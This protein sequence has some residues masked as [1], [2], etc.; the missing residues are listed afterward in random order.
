MNAER[1]DETPEEAALDREIQALL[2][3][4]PSP[5]FQASLR[6]RI[7]DA[8]ASPV[9]GVWRLVTGAAAVAAFVVVWVVVSRP[10]PRT[11]SNTASTVVAPTLTAREFI[12]IGLLMSPPPLPARVAVVARSRSPR[13]MRTQPAPDILIA[14]DERRAL[15]ALIVGVREGRVDLTPVTQA[16]TP[17][18]MELEPI[19][20]LVIA[21]IVITPVEGVHP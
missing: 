5:R 2:A 7:A 10:A 12:D 4:D 3:V 15:I 13:R 20:N 14:P 1:I 6:Q 21:P 19:R 11:S 16:T 18:V 9:Y 17:S 8:Q